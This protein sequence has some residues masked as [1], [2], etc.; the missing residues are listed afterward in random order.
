MAAPPDE[1]TAKIEAAA[2]VAL[3]AWVMSLGGGVFRGTVACGIDA[4]SS[5][6]AYCYAHTDTGIIAA[7]SPLPD[8]RGSDW[9]FTLLAGS[10]GADGNVAIPTSVPQQPSPTVAAPPLTTVPIP[11]VA[12]SAPPATSGELTSTFGEGKQ[13]VNVDVAPGRYQAPGS[14]FC[15]WERLSAANNDLDN[16]ISNAIIHGPAVADIVATDVAF[17]SQGCGTWAPYVAPPAPATTFGTG[18]YVVGS[19][20]APGTYEANGGTDC[21]W[22]R[23]GS[24]TADFEDLLAIENMTQPGTVVIEATD[25]GFEASECGTWTLVSGTG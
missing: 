23:L 4:V 12:E 17:S 22:R 7:S 3:E 16:L 15:Y 1:P 19:D 9:Q 2:E 13:L 8:P 20:I 5:H 14:D 21:Y 6:T 18:A 25:V 11:T 24:F 10:I